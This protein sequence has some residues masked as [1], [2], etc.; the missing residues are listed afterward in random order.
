MDMD[1]KSIG[2][3]AFKQGCL[4]ILD[5]VA[6]HQREVIITKRGKPVAKLVPVTS[7]AEREQEILRRLRGKGCVLVSEEEL[8]RPVDAEWEA[9]G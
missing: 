7:S 6:E 9:L 2:A 5:E 1:T 4:A 8:L 3:G